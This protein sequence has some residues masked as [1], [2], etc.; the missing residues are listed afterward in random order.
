MASDRS[1]YIK[2][3]RDVRIDLSSQTIN[4]LRANGYT[5][6]D[7]FMHCDDKDIEGIAND[8]QIARLD[9]IKLKL[10]INRHKNN[11]NQQILPMQSDRVNNVIN[12]IDSDDDNHNQQR[13]VPSTLNAFAINDNIINNA[14]PPLMTEDNQIVENSQISRNKS[15]NSPQNTQVI[16]NI[17]SIKTEYIEF[18]EKKN[19]E[20]QITNTKN[21][22]N[23][24]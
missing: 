2:W 4:S 10:A 20:L 7:L 1:Q 12:L 21:T 13:S 11:N 24:N 23:T 5:E 18:N 8:Y 6:T 17:Q 22:N 9:K 15:N 14:M 3:F 19:I 16:K